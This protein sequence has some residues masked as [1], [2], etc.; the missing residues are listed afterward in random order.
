MNQTKNYMQN[1]SIVRPVLTLHSK[2]I[3]V[4]TERKICEKENEQR[5]RPEK[6]K[7]TSYL[8]CYT[9]EGWGRAAQKRAGKSA[10]IHRVGQNNNI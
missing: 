3:E 7:Q 10:C 1:V 8:S 5:K 9:L 2:D 4:N 6:S